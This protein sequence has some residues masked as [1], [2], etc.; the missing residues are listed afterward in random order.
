MKNTYRL[1]VK[2]LEMY[3]HQTKKA[4]ATITDKETFW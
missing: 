2:R 3:K 4:V 1:K